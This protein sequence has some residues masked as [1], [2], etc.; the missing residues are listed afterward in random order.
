MPSFLYF[1]MPSKRSFRFSVVYLVKVA[2][3]RT[4]VVILLASVS[5]AVVSLFSSI[6]SVYSD[7]VSSAFECN[8]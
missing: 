7:I 5:V 8:K 1:S 4:L 3:F 2:S 6:L